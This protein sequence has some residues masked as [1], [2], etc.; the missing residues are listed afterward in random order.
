MWVASGNKKSPNGIVEAYQIRELVEMGAV[1]QT[2]LSERTK[3]DLL[4]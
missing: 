3:E 2:V 4:S 1:L